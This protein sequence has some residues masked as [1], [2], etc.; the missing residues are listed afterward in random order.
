MPKNPTNT[1]GYKAVSCPRC[2]E[3]IEVPVRVISTAIDTV[4]FFPGKL[5]VEFDTQVVDHVCEEVIL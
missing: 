3:Q 4:A 2:G 5:V 1:T